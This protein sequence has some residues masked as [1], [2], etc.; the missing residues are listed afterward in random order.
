MTNVESKP[1]SVA[2]SRRD[3]FGTQRPY[4]GFQGSFSNLTLGRPY[5][6]GFCSVSI[7]LIVD[8]VAGRFFHFSFGFKKKKIWTKKISKQNGAVTV[9]EKT[10]CCLISIHFIHSIKAKRK[11]VEEVKTKKIKRKHIDKILF[12]IVKLK[13]GRNF[14]FWS[15]VMN[16]K[17]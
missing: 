10:V 11:K 15:F 7:I 16:A 9:A 4:Y 1:I 2:Y 13:K 12:L 8:T 14:F 17:I 3:S 5:E 6:K